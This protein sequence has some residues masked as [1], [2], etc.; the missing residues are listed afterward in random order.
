M[1]FILTDRLGHASVHSR[2]LL[3]SIAEREK[4]RKEKKE[5]LFLWVLLTFLQ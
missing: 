3:L 5:E 4:K 2:E 1:S